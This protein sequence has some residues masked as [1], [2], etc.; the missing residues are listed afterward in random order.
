MQRRSSQTVVCRAGCQVDQRASCCHSPGATTPA[1]RPATVV[2]LVTSNDE[3]C[4]TSVMW[5]SSW[6]RSWTRRSAWTRLSP[7]RM[8]L[9]CRIFP[10]CLETFRYRYDTSAPVPAP[11]IGAEVSWGRS[12]RK[13][14]LWY[15]SVAFGILQK[16][17]TNTTTGT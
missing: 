15:P 6:T 7:I 4:A 8:L 12:V 11:N 5:R 16:P 10:K 3:C 9:V 14:S 13:A 2:L 1:R 17:S